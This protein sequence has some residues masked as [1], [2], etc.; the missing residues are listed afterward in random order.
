MP[1]SPNIV[2][3]KKSRYRRPPSW[4]KDTRDSMRQLQRV[5]MRWRGAMTKTSLLSYYYR[6]KTIRRLSSAG[7]SQRQIGLELGLT[8]QAISATINKFGGGGKYHKLLELRNSILDLFTRGARAMAKKYKRQPGDP[9]SR[10]E[11]LR[12]YKEYVIPRGRGSDGKD[13]QR[14]KEASEESW[15][16]GQ[17]AE[18]TLEAGQT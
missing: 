16:D 17:G 2:K 11:Y 14:P 3:S 15:W 1:N 8:R 13:T 7:W 12:Q 18:I 9:V 4:L 5:N 6:L 10:E